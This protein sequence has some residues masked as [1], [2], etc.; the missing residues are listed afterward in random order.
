MELLG[1]EKP[2][3]IFLQGGREVNAVENW[4]G[5]LQNDVVLLISVVE[6]E[7]DLVMTEAVDGPLALQDVN[8]YCPVEIFAKQA[9]VAKDSKEQ[10]KSAA[11][12]LPGILYAVG[13]PNLHPGTTFPTGAVLVSRGWVHPPL[14][15]SD[16]GC[17]MAWYKTNLSRSHVE[18][19]K[20]GR[21]ADKLRG[22][23][24]PWRDQETR[25][26]WLEFGEETCSAGE[27]WDKALGTVGAGSR[28]YF[29]QS[30]VPTS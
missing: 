2:S 3:R 1:L 29:S 14:V 17:G 22:L 25:E 10:L 4:S 5:F 7:E 15:G 18:G 24:G 23:E 16:I 11:R 9:F 28:T 12:F 13:Q 30:F 6:E 8:P 21:F 19:D 26:K 27:H 20:G